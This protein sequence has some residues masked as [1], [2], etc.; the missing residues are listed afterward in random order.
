MMMWCHVEKD[1]MMIVRESVGRREQMPGD[2]M[3]DDPTIEKQV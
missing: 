3:N 1:L 2:L